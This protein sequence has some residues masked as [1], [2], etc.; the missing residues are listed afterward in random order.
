MKLEFDLENI[1]KDQSI[2]LLDKSFSSLSKFNLMEKFCRID[3]FFYQV[4]QQFSEKIKPEWSGIT[5]AVQNI[6]G[7]LKEL[8][9]EKYQ[10]IKD[11]IE[12]DFTRVLDIT[13]RELIS[14]S[15]PE[16]QKKYVESIVD[17][18]E[19]VNSNLQEGL[20]KISREINKEKEEVIIS[21]NGLYGTNIKSKEKILETKKDIVEDK[22]SEGFGLEDILIKKVNETVNGFFSKIKQ[23]NP[24]EYLNKYLDK[25]LKK[26]PASLTRHFYQERK[27]IQNLT[28]DVNSYFEELV[29][30]KQKLFNENPSGMLGIK[31][32]KLLEFSDKDK[33][34]E[35]YEKLNVSIRDLDYILNLASSKTYQIIHVKENIPIIGNFVKKKAKEMP[36]IE[37]IASLISKQKEKLSTMLKDL[38]GSEF[39]SESE[40]KSRYRS[41][42]EKTLEKEYSIDSVKYPE[43]YSTKEERFTRDMYYTW[44][45]YNSLGEKI[46]GTIGAI[47]KYIFSPLETKK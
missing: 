20:A 46:I 36:K 3:N 47:L 9:E 4:P 5:N 26:V 45:D 42:M 27:Y 11:S 16:K 31:L 24:Q 43:E 2:R 28:E 41:R 40:I 32:R 14:F 37:E 44:H 25:L 35:F 30:E 15:N 13:P 21:I 18:I 38:Y 10:F 33:Q 12:Q 17:N 6:D 29:K 7:W 22:F 8:K 39:S 34:K 23:F 1:L 19:N